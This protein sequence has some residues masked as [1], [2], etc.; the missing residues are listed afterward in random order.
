[1]KKIDAF[2]VLFFSFNLANLNWPE[3]QST[4]YKCLVLEY[5]YKTICITNVLTYLCL[6]KILFGFQSSTVFKQL[7]C[8]WLANGLVFKFIFECWTKNWLQCLVKV[9]CTG[10][11]WNVG[12]LSVY[13]T[14]YS[15]LP[16]SVTLQYWERNIRCYIY[17]LCFTDRDTR[18]D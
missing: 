16:L 12:W 6:R 10:H 17:Y 13:L 2:I 7:V 3:E 14:N 4:S 15:V 9:T 5:F 8:L 11:H 1:M 18:Y